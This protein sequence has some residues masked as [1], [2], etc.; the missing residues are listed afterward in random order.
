MLLTVLILTLIA[1]IIGPDLLSFTV[2]LI[3]VPVTFVACAI[4]MVVLSV[5][6]GLIIFPVSIVYITVCMD[7]STSAICLICLP[8]SFVQRSID[9]DLHSSSV[10]ATHLVPFAF[11]LCSVVESY[12]R[13]L[14][15]INTIRRWRW[16]ILEWFKLVS[17]LHDES[18]SFHDL[19]I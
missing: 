17:D 14:D 5:T 2:L 9:P 4:S 19:C 16:L 15:S 6:V 18:T 8:V 11:V 7:K 3:L 13:S 1:G 12:E 10:F